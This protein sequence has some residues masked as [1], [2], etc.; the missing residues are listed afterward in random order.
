MRNCRAAALIERQA[1]RS[2]CGDDRSRASSRPTTA[3]LAQL[4]SLLAPNKRHTYL[5][6]YVEQG[7]L[8]A[9]ALVLLSSQGKLALRIVA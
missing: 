4:E 1:T 7:V 9:T 2:A 8:G 6:V 5:R 3:T